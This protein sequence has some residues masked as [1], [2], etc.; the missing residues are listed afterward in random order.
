LQLNY[1]LTGFFNGFSDLPT[2]TLRER[3]QK[4]KRRMKIMREILI[5]RSS[6]R[7]I[8]IRQVTQF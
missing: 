7:I 4:R 8:K 5:L 2:K 6:S 3:N 1:R